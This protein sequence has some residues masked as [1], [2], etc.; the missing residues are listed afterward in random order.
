MKSILCLLSAVLLLSCSKEKAAA[1]DPYVAFTAK[2][3]NA[4]KYIEHELS[5]NLS[6]GAG[7]TPRYYTY[8]AIP[9]MFDL[10]RDGKTPVLQVSMDNG[11]KLA[12]T[13]LDEDLVK[14]IQFQPS[15]PMLYIHFSVTGVNVDP[16]RQGRYI[17]GVLFNV[18]AN[19][20]SD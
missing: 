18:E 4:E 1:P 5:V 20:L 7:K 16:L 10:Y 8:T 12:L 19:A 14:Y 11:D 6:P 17:D 2:F 15:S 13:I 9:T 3:P